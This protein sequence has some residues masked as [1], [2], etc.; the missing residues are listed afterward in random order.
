MYENFYI[1]FLFDLNL[2]SV[3]FI[4]MIFVFGYSFILKFVISL[5]LY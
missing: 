1:I 2:V 5:I 3:V 4:Y